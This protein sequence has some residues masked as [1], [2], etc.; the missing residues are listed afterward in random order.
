MRKFSGEK[1]LNNLVYMENQENS[2]TRSLCHLCRPQASS[3]SPEGEETLRPPWSDLR[4]PGKISRLD[5]PP[6]SRWEFSQKVRERTT[7]GDQASVSKAHSFILHYF[8]QGLLYPKLHIED[9]R[10][11]EIMQS[12]QSLILIETKLSFL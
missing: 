9:N 10:G 11:C 3:R 6:R 8:Q 5:E 4:S 12:Q 7:W 1:R 2:K